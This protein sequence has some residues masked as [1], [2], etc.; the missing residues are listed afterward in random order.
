MNKNFFIRDQPASL[1]TLREPYLIL[2]FR[3]T[4]LSAESF[5]N[6]HEI[7]S[8][9][10]ALSVPR[11]NNRHIYYILKIH[12]S[13]TCFSRGLMPSRLPQSQTYA[14]II[15]EQSR[16][17]PLPI[18]R[19]FFLHPFLASFSC[20]FFPVSFGNACLSHASIS[21]LLFA[22]PTGT[23]S[24]SVS[25][26]CLFILASLSH[27]TRARALLST[28]HLLIQAKQRCPHFLYSAPIPR[29]DSNVDSKVDMPFNVC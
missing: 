18:F 4:I 8:I 2:F 6:F 17:M 12:F 29:S 28:T 20:I 5:R 14:C 26:P 22:S 9:T 16:P 23:Q 15:F 1:Q 13:S 3:V 21:L 24:S 27:A 11:L 25:F 10:K 19:S 7:M